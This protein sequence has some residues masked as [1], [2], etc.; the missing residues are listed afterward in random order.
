MTKATPR[1]ANNIEEVDVAMNERELDQREFGNLI[2]S[3][4]V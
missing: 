1:L 4:K 3:D 2:G